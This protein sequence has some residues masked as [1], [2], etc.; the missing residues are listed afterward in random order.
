MMTETKETTTRRNALAALAALPMAA[1]M[2]NPATASTA[3]DA[4]TPVGKLFAEWAT[5]YEVAE[6]AASEATDDELSEL[7]DAKHQLE[8]RIMQTPSETPLDVL[9][10]VAAWTSFGM[11]TLSD[12]A[13]DE[14]VG[15]VW[16]EMHD[17]C[18]VPV[19]P[20]NF[21]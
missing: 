21:I 11:F 20:S 19:L 13:N 14:R 18:G 17:A 3:P 15:L 9:C 10:K 2:A 7:L 6:T 16:Q 8:L 5:A 12:P 4:E 1:A